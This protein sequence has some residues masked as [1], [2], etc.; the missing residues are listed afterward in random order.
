MMRICVPE[1]NAHS[2]ADL[3]AGVVLERG[4]GHRPGENRY[5]AGLDYRVQLTPPFGRSAARS[6]H[7]ALT[8]VDEAPTLGVLWIDLGQS[9]L[10]D[11]RALDDIWEKLSAARMAFAG[12]GLSG[13]SLLLPGSRPGHLSA[14]YVAERMQQAGVDHRWLGV[15]LCPERA[16]LLLEADREAE[17]EP[18][19]IAMRRLGF[20]L[21]AE[22]PSFREGTERAR[23]MQEVPGAD[24]P[25]RIANLVG[26]FPHFDRVRIE[27]GDAATIRLVAGLPAARAV[28]SPKIRTPLQLP[29]RHRIAPRVLADAAAAGMNVLERV[30]LLTVL[31][32]CRVAM[33]TTSTPGRWRSV[34][35]FLRTT[36]LGVVERSRRSRFRRDR[37]KGGWSNLYDES[38]DVGRREVFV[39]IARDQASA[40]G[41]ARLEAEDEEA[42]GIMLGYPTCCRAAFQ[43]NFPSALTHQGDLVPFVV[44]QTAALPPW[45]FLLNPVG[46]YFDAG[47]VSFYPCSLTCARALQIAREAW[48]VLRDADLREAERLRSVLAAPFLYTEYRGIYRLQGDAT[49]RNRAHYDAARLRG[50]ANSALCRLLAEGDEVACGADDLVTVWR[51]GERVGRRKAV[52]A[53]LFSF[54]RDP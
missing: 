20:S 8:G 38:A 33:R 7:H 45:S 10:P 18:A 24:L 11:W 48:E 40:D 30:E 19:F 39:Y 1:V 47:F 36:G 17:G 12:V 27:D 31:S 3:P 4:L 37:G 22:L 21:Q 51:N 42:F 13:L 16:Q 25:G 49:D 14:E 26:L 5:A 29:S 35:P 54:A 41:A 52:N 34:A 32:G 44:D 6:L 9:P 23:L 46:R 50:T 43:R 2:L 53:R 15:P 28:P